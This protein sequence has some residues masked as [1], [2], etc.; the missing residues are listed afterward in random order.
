MEHCGESSK[1]G[2]GTVDERIRPASQR[3]TLNPKVIAYTMS[4]LCI[5]CGR[6]LTRQGGVEL[7]LVCNSMAT[8]AELAVEPKTVIEC[9]GATL[10]DVESGRILEGVKWN[11]TADFTLGHVIIKNEVFAPMHMTRRL[12]AADQVGKIARCQACQ[13]H[14]VRMR[15]QQ[16][17]HKVTGPSVAR[18]RAEGLFKH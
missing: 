7:C 13:D 3:V 10:Y 6:S 8:Q 12:L 17:D 5:H 16:R 11:D 18:K 2:A 4:T 9:P 15:A 1:L 14:T